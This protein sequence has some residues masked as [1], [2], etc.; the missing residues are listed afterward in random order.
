[1]PSPLPFPRK[2][3]V[4]I[5]IL[6]AVV[7]C[8]P[9]GPRPVPRV[10]QIGGNLK[11]AQGDDGYE[12]LQ[13]VWAFCYPASWQYIERSQAIPQPSG[14]DRTFGITNVPSNTPP[15]GQP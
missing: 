8:Q 10:P 13:A 5:A 9:S 4:A 15:P 7:G 2:L 3:L 1:M 14:L 11:G 12:D 6:A